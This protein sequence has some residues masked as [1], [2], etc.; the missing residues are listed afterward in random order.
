MPTLIRT[1]SKNED[2]RHLVT[3]LDASLAETD[4][5]EHAFYHQFNGI[6]NIKYVL[7]AYLDNVA[8]GCG[9]IKEYEA[10]T[11]EVKRMY[12][13]PNYRGQGVASQILG[14]LENWAVELGYDYCVLETG[15]RQPDA[16][17]LYQKNNYEI[18]VNYG[19]YTEVENS[20]CMKKRVKK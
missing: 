7:V 16:I 4:G 13:L 8:V 20:V 14:A 5:D 3:L 2:F 15:K 17:A 9:A 12:V 10:D 6:D 1:D 18:I 19:Q 11:V